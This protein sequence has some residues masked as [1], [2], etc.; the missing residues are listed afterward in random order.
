MR[1]S[2]RLDSAQVALLTPLRD[3]LAAHNTARIDSLR[4]TVGTGN[5]QGAMM[6]A[7]PAMRPLFEA[8]RSEISQSLVTVRAILRPEQWDMLPESV[9]NFQLG[10]RM[11]MQQAPRP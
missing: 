6:R 10:P 2:L 3:S 5:D 9:R 8:A 1:D 4:R 11:M 7:M